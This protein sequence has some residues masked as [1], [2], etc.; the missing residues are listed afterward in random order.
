MEPVFQES[1]DS[2]LN[3]SKPHDSVQ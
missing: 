3:G 1:G 2:G